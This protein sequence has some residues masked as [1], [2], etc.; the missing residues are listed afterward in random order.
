MNLKL[1]NLR[2][3][4][5][6]LFCAAFCFFTG[7]SS[8]SSLKNEPFVELDESSYIPEKIEWKK[9]NSFSEY[10]LFEN[11]K[12]PL[13]YHLVK[14]ELSPQNLKISAYPSKKNE[15]E[16]GISAASFAKKSGSFVSINTA[17]FKG[18]FFS[19]RKI[20]GIYKIQGRV[21]SE[22]NGRYSALGFKTEKDGSLK[23][24]IANQNELNSIEEFDYIFG[25]FFEILKNNEEIEFL[26]SS[27]NS[28][29]AAGISSDGKTL[30]LLV[31]EGERIFLSKGL[32][33]GE[34]AKILK[35]AGSAD[36]LEFDGGSSSSLFVNGKNMLL[37]RNFTKCA[38]FFGFFDSGK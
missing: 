38:A 37:Y 19:K 20:V 16:K 25:G 5:F 28:R 11:K 36:G 21:F 8:L 14:V 22:K 32:S 13:R 18:R 9:I 10:F 35:F 26:Y 17:P 7:C 34:C 29:T 1:M 30:F 4:Y 27:R 2:K 12:V 6:F 15:L 23:A 33:Y 3:T 31:V 24:F